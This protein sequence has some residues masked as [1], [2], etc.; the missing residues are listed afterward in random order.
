MRRRQ[1][2]TIRRLG[3]SRKL[4][5]RECTPLEGQGRRKREP[6]LVPRKRPI[7]VPDKQG[8]N[9]TKWDR[10]DCKPELLALVENKQLELVPHRPAQPVRTMALEVVLLVQSKALRRQP[11]SDRRESVLDKQRERLLRTP[12]VAQ[13]VARG[14][15]MVGGLISNLEKNNLIIKW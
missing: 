2:W 6:V 10:V 15:G 1:R 7:E 5:L 8:L 14:L 9:R 12:A 4:V 13:Q 3:P 11:V